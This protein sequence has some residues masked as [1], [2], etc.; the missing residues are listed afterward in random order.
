MSAL[1]D[2]LEQFVAACNHNLR[3]QEMNH[4]WDRLILVQPDDAAE[5]HWIRY[6]AGVAA[7]VAADGEPDLIVEGASGVLVSI[8]SGASTPTEPYMSGDLRVRGS[9]DDV[10]RLDIIALLIWGE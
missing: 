5:E 4:D 2:T 7:V 1:G 6:H 10:M 9:Q 8:F 3:L